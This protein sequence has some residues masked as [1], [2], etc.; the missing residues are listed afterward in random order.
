MTAIVLVISLFVEISLLG[1]VVLYYLSFD[2]I[3]SAK[4]IRMIVKQRISQFTLYKGSNR[5]N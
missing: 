5:L 4:G 2:E 1:S 3:R